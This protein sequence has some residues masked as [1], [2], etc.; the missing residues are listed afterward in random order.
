MACRDLIVEHDKRATNHEEL[1]NSLK[2]VNLM[3]QKASR[4]RVG[5]AK[6]RIA[7]ACRAAIKGDNM[8]TL[9]RII[10]EGVD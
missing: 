5:G 2:E 1:L 4:L 10:K 3:I 6:T 7:T 9:I 8:A